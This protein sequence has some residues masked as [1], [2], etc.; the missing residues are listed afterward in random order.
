MRIHAFEGLTPDKCGKSRTFDTCRSPCLTLLKQNAGL[1]TAIKV[2]PGENYYIV[3]NEDNYVSNVP[4]YMLENIFSLMDNPR[5]REVA[6]FFTLKEG[7][8]GASASH[9]R[10]ETLF[11]RL[12]HLNLTLQP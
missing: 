3:C 11:K 5:F 4:E 1:R 10:V 9:P 8:G 2:D 12:V 6:G 7:E